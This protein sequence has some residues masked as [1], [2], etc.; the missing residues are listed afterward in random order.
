M[1]KQA[2]YRSKSRPQISSELL[3]KAAIGSQTESRAFF[4]PPFLL[5]NSPVVESTRCQLVTGCEDLIN[6]VVLGGK[7]P[8]R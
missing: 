6:L 4:S 1:L 2:L 7:M 3:G 8:R 5:S